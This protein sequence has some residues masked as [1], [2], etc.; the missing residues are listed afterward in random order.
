MTNTTS[1]QDLSK[2]IEEVI[3][4]HIA[5][6]HRAAT[7]ALER[8]FAGATL[9]PTKAGGAR[10]ARAE[11]VSARR[12]ASQEMSAVGVRLYQAVCAKPGAAMTVLAADVGATP[13]ALNRPMMH[14]KR[15][16]KVRSVGQRHL[17]RYFPLVDE[18]TASA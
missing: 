12:R 1:I 18:A 2:K 10:R 4:E 16:G 11:G 14:L 8:A 9:E 7:A 5:A 3:Q 15:A 13:R 17:T 6:S